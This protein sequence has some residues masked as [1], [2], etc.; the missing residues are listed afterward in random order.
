VITEAGADFGVLVEL[1]ELQAEER[2]LRIT[3]RPVRTRGG[4]DTTYALEDGRI[5]YVLAAEVTLFDAR[6][7][8]MESFRVQNEGSEGFRRARYEG[9]PDELE[10]SRGERLLFNPGEERRQR[11]ILQSSLVAGLGRDLAEGVFS[12]L[13]RRIP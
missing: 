6:G 2:D 3:R 10:L 1:V 12:R 11:E 5:R 13:L 9:T 4:T 8:R 7:V